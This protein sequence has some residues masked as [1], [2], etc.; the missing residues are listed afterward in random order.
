M[1]QK[2]LLVG[3]LANALQR[4]SR[5]AA[6][7]SPVSAVQISISFTH[8]GKESSKLDY[9]GWDPADGGHASQKISEFRHE[10]CPSANVEA[11]SEIAYLKPDGN[12]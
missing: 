4:M 2:A 9:A 1:K 12:L 6:I 8:Q 10:L 3:T 7:S 5:H 11:C